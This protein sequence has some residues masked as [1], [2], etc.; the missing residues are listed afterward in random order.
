VA[1]RRTGGVDEPTAARWQRGG[2]GGDT[3]AKRRR[4]GLYMDARW[5]SLLRSLFSY[6]LAP[7][8]REPVQG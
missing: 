8:L 3:V 7:P 1:E 2:W 6:L 5:R 4:T